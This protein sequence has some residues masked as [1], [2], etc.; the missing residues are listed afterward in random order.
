M[1][2]LRLAISCITFIAVKMIAG[3]PG[4]GLVDWDGVFGALAKVNYDRWLVIE[5][6]TPAV[7]EIA[8]ATCIWRD[9]AP[10]A[11]SL[12]TDGLAFLKQKAAEY[13]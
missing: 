5:S 8:A 13:L 3:H 6:F 10:S 11:E 12:A 2:L 4:T 1:L 9:I 7:K